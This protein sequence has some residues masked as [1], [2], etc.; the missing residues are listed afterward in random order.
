M[1]ESARLSET[2]IV[3]NQ[4]PYSVA[5]RQ[6]VD[7]GVLA[8][9]QEN[10]IVN[11]YICINRTLISYILAFNSDAYVIKIEKSTATI[12]CISKTNEH[13]FFNSDTTT[14]I[15]VNYLIN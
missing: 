6:Y 2:P 7:N 14:H 13:V 5:T 4:V 15:I 3:T 8:Y 11:L 1:E 10:E 12:I 9:C